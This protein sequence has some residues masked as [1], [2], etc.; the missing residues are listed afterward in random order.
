[1]ATAETK[2]INNY[3]GTHPPIW[4]FIKKIK[5]RGVKYCSEV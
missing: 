2:K 3:F 4:K 5:G 1:M